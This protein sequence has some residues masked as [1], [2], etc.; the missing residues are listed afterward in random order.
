MVGGVAVQRPGEPFG[1][2]LGQRGIGLGHEAG[3]RVVDRA[4]AVVRVH[5]TAECHTGEQEQGGERDPAALH[6]AS[7]ED[8][9]A[10]VAGGGRGVAKRRVGLSVGGRLGARRGNRACA[11]GARGRDP[12]ARPA[13]AR[14]GAGL[15]T[16]C[17]PTRGPASLRALR[18]V[19]EESR[20]RDHNQPRERDQQRNQG[21]A[22]H[23]RDDI[24]VGA[25]R[26]V[27]QHVVAQCEHADDG[28]RPYGPL[29]HALNPSG[30]SGRMGC[31]G[32][33]GVDKRL[34]RSIT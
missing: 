14:I 23:Q 27:P 22:G 5:I 26:P 29:R 17:A 24:V 31:G 20:D 16:G 18:G 6:A 7:F 25:D 13:G 8:G 33:W 9:E 10:A 2:A 19:G 15:S 11:A 28:Q 1:P 3:V 4:G 30:V 32:W 21:H 12:H 34:E